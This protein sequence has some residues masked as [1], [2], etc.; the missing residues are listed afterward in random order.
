MN[1]LR[2]FIPRAALVALVALAAAV[3]ALTVTPLVPTASAYVMSD[4]CSEYDPDRGLT[5]TCVPDRS[6]FYTPDGDDP[7]RVSTG[8]NYSG[9]ATS[10]VPAGSVATGFGFEAGIHM[11]DPDPCCSFQ[12]P[13]PAS[14]RTDRNYCSK[15]WWAP[16]GYAHRL[17]HSCYDH[18]VCYGSQLGRK[19]CDV[20]FWSEMVGACKEDSW[21]NPSRYTCFAQARAW[22]YA[23]RSYG[24]D[25]Y[26]PRTSSS[27]PAGVPW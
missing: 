6:T 1:T 19:Y 11:T 13:P 4:G 10:Q 22:Y 21:Y 25:H 5:Y 8:T 27:E 15:P 2:T 9:E 3:P 7:T 12:I 17:N 16:S 23:V 24:G 18:D 26:K 14:Y 20:R